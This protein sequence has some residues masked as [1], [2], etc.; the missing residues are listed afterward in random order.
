MIHFFGNVENTV[1]AV[2]THGNI[3][4]ENIKKLEWLFGNQPKI[5]Q[6]VL[7]INPTDFFIGPRA[8]MVTPWST[9]AVEITQNMAV[10]GI[11]RIEEFHNSTFE[12]GT[13]DPM[14]SQKFKELNQDIFDIH[15]QP[16]AILEIEN[17]S[18]YNQKEGLALNAEEVEYLENLSEKLGRKLTDSEVFGFSQVN[19]EHC[20]HKIFNGV[21]EIDGKEMPSSLFKLIKKTSAENPN[22]IVSAYKDNVAF[23]KGPKVKQW[24][25]KSGDKPD[26]YEEKDFESVI[27]IKAETHNFPTTVEPFNGAATGSGGE[28]RDRL[29]GGKGSLPLAGTAVYMTSYSRLND[30]RP[31]EKGMKERDW[32]YQTPLDILIKA[33]NGASDFGNKFGQPL[34]AGSVLTFEHEEEARRLGFDKVIMLAGGI[35]YGKATQA[36]KGKPQVGDKI[37]VLGGDNYRIGMGGAAVSSAD[38]GEFHSG[39]ELNAIQ[40]SNPEMQ[41][42]AANAIRAMVESD[43]N[44]IVSIHDHGAGGHLNCLS[45]LVEDSGGRI[46]LDK[47]PIGDPT[48]SAKEIMG[49][50]SQERMGLIINEENIQKLKK[51][52]DRERSPMYEVGVVTGDQRFCF[53]NKKGEKPMDFALEDMFGSSPKTIMKDKTVNRNYKNPDYEVSK[54]KEYLEQV[55][56]LEAVACK[57]WLTNKVDRCVTGRV[58]KQQTAGPLQLPL[59]NCG[60][61]ALDYHGK[62]GVATSIGHSPLTALIDPAAGSRNAITESLTNIV[63]AP[64]K[65]GLKSVSLSANWMWPCNNEGEDARLY[66][67]VKAVSEFSIDLGINVPTGKDSLSMK[68]KYKDGEVISPGTV[69]ISAAGNC[70][71][72]KK[73]V[74]PV[75]QKNGGS[76][77]Y[78]NISQDKFKLGGS[79]F[80]QVLNSIGNAAPDVKSAD[81]VKTV[82]NTL[83]ALIKEGKILAGHD[84]ASGGLITTLLEMCFADVNLGANLDLSGLGESDMV[85]LLFAENAGV[86]IQASENV[87]V[88]K[89]LTE[90]NIDFKKIGTVSENETLQIKNNSEELTFSIPEMRDAWYKTSYLLDRNQSGERLAKERFSNYKN[91]PLK[92][93]F[94][95][96][97]NGKLPQ[98]NSE[99]PKIKAA[100]IREKG[101]NS[102]REMAYMMHLA[103]F[104]VKDVHMT[105]LIEGREDLE[106]IKLLVAVG[107]FSNS[108]VLGSAKG[109]AGAFLYNEKANTA[110]KNF[111]AKED[112]LSL[113]V[114]NGCQLF[115]ELGLLNPEDEEKPK[116]LHN[117][118]GKFECTFT[119]VKIQEN[120][121]VM[122][123]SMTGSTLGIWSAHGEGKFS[124]PNKESHYNIV[125]KYGYDALP[126]NPNGSDFNTAMMTDKTGRHLVMMPHLERSTFPWNWA[127][128]P[129]DRMN[130]EVSPWV[131]ALVNAREWIEKI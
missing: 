77:Y 118:T 56:Q 69:I 94:P 4:E 54:I 121:S 71:D 25:P 21:F 103:G 58:A 22:D 28:I 113:G 27:S 110:L 100:V 30:E 31:W 5:K 78:I 93:E 129:K 67:A 65:D 109:W 55:L 86:V 19:S 117:D 53:E 116:M 32:L 85:K 106:E 127:Y 24:A 79:S 59:N 33:S 83:Q 75:L 66:E 1:F 115:V 11:V 6:S 80:G 124:F 111:F 84:V 15:V 131:Q 8:A 39:I 73:V 128:Y 43:E 23:V 2:Q 95:K 35:G 89:M 63:W 57:D 105:D 82:F 29:A 108:D 119:S 88:E 70:N 101:S 62:E 74:E 60:V 37:V 123:S 125:A 130:D 120:N 45:E 20:R 46:E 42:R 122:L 64:L 47:L 92:F 49:N 96:N 102:E 99:T 16:E 44:P 9:N 61:M 68:Q 104:D 126:A 34:I 98:L 112:T 72:I 114:C 48:L 91:Q 36:I 38:T 87:S 12:K 51:V 3:S 7:S 41:K 50:E 17:I 13:F 26:W 76:I 18:E 40:R 14:L 107:G 52:A 81:Y 10:E 90:K 97:F